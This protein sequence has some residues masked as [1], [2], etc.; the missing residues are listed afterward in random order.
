MEFMKTAS[1]PARRRHSNV[2]RCRVSPEAP[3]RVTQANAELESLKQKLLQDV[4]AMS[5]VTAHRA[6]RRAA[7]EAA[8]LAW[9]TP[10]P[11][12]ILPELLKEKA[13]LAR[14]QAAKQQSVFERSQTILAL[15]V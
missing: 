2:S 4:L 6:I 5:P 15:A 7:E 12:L 14:Q 10:Y 11:L 1:L 8:S 13:H 3:A 9:L